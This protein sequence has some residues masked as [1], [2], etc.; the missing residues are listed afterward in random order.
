MTRERV[1]ILGAAGRDF[2]NF[3]VVFRDDPNV[4]VVAFTATQIPK[5][6]GRT[7]PRELA[8]PQYPD[9]IP[10]VPEDDLETSIREK[11]VDR[12]IM[13][14][15]DLS[16]EQ[17]MHLASRTIG[18][19]ADFSMLGGRTML[20]SSVPV[21]A[22]C[23][24]RTGSGKSQ[25]SRAVVETLKSAGLRV[26]AVRHPMPYGDLR[27][28]AVQRFGSLQDLVKHE[29]TIEEREEYEAHI[30]EGTVVYA[31][32]DYEAIL[33]SAEKEA[34]VV[35]WDGGNNDLPFY[36]PNLWITVADALRP[37]H[38]HE[39]HPGEANF[40]A[41]D[42]ILVNKV[43]DANA[44]D[45]DEVV[46]S[47]KALNP[48]ARVILGASEVTVDK[49]E[50]I[51]GKS[52]VLVEDGPTLTHGGMPYGAGKV[53]AERSGAAK[54]VDPRPYAV[55][56]IRETFEKYPHIGALVP[57]MGYWDEQIKDLEATLKATPSDTVVVATP[58]DLGALVKID[59]PMVRAR[60]ALA[61]KGAEELRELVGAF[62][63]SAKP[64]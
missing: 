48:R 54:I 45:V 60:Y 40:R 14:Y 16:H 9:G 38:E 61:G 1:V 7:Y 32:V 21:V 49:P 4:E 64:G 41:A 58:I 17:V 27:K 52:V 28:Q 11:R 63:K 29:C 10:I 42:V 47:A 8:G 19:G 36:R 20:D 34:D 18:Q 55:G 25:T 56:S 5:I 33:R 44:K 30:L 35:V 59:K 22:V 51:K 50:L 57:A 24:V 6:A 2:H 62:A 13:A 3:N 12:V 46:A 15:S 26:V 43:N 39:Y 23:A 53:A 37:G 31:G